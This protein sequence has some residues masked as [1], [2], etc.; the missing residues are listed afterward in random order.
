[1]PYTVSFL[2]RKL[3]QS[4]SFDS[5]IRFPKSCDFVKKYWIL[6][7]YKKQGGSIDITEAEEKEKEHKSF[8]SYE[9]K[10]SF[11]G[12]ELVV[13]IVQSLSF[14]DGFDFFRVLRI[15]AKVLM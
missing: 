1:M 9:I 7:E 6:K 8:S 12:N 15:I 2:D 3:H 13:E 5:D 10:K 4:L 14:S 11:K